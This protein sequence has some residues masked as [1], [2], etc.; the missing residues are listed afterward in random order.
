MTDSARA[1][2]YGDLVA[3]L[4]DARDDRA[5]RRFDAELSDAVEDG[6]VDPD[7]ARRLR[8]LQRESVH[9]VVEHART[10]VPAAL[11]G[12]DRARVEQGVEHRVPDDTGAPETRRRDETPY[13]DV[14]NE[15]DR[16]SD[17][18]VDFVVEPR[19]LLVAGLTVLPTDP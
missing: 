3:G 16:D 15:V 7:V 4:L 11:L 5:T 19:R 10:T 9:A 17:F 6:L 1:A 8:W 12:L 14:D 2:A 18:G 13:Q